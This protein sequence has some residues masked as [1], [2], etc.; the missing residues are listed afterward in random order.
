MK[1]VPEIGIQIGEI[2]LP[3][4]T[5]DLQKWA[6]IACDQF[7]SQPEYW[8][9]VREIVGAAPS[10]LN[11]IL[12]EVYLGTREEQARI[13]STQAA[14]RRYLDEQILGPQ[15][16]FILVE[17]TVTGQDGA[18][19][20]RRGLMLALDLERYDF[21]KGSQSLIRATEGTIL[22]RL[23]PRIRIRE[24]APLEVPHI[25]VLI[26]DP[27][28]TVIEPLVEAQARSRR[29]ELRR[30]YDTDLMQGSG[31]LHGS[32]V[33][34]PA[35]ETRTIQA[36]KK[37]A[38][39]ERFQNHYGVG[40]D[41]GVLLFAVGDGNHSLATAKSIWENIKPQVG[42]D[43]PARY[44]LV[45]IEN[46]HDEGLSFEPIHRVLF[47]LHQDWKAGLDSQ[48][49]GKMH[50][51]PSA[52]PGE[53]IAAVN[54]QSGP[55]QSFG[56]INNQGAGV[57]SILDAPANLPVGTLQAFLDGWLKQG[58]A[59]HIDYVHGDEVV[60][61]LGAQPGNLGFYLP[62]LDKGDLFKTV[63]LDG[64]LPRKTFSMG[65]AHEKRFY[66]ESRKIT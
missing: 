61:Q 41:K 5:V 37:L 27:E 45:E 13:H 8:Q 56:V 25:L 16:G 64:S 65:E 49:G 32:L 38:E 26:D 2:L 21:S 46:V 22:E 7:T 1:N 42:M 35:L 63:I 62:A 10:T 39:P 59:D 50:Y 29:N 43:H 12:P 28:R 66:M 30:L 47:G 9:Q 60:C 31:H 14:M 34:D 58:A 17:R 52:S 4:E 6:V 36:L 44:A 23:P 51:A 3:N 15:Q 24:G 40:P 18:P 19:H 48:F 11:M 53:M 54:R 55:G 57:V 20:T 33:V